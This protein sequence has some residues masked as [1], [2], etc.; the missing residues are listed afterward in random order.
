M[1]STTSFSQVITPEEELTILIRQAVNNNPDIE[2]WK[3][4][5]KASGERIP[6]AGSWN[7][8]I[9]TLG[10]NNL[11][12]NSFDFN[13]E[14]MTAF[15]ATFG[16]S[17]PLTGKY[18]QKKDIARFGYSIDST[19]MHD[20]ELTIAEDISR[21]YYELLFL[22]S[23]SATIDSTIG[24]KK[25]ILRLARRKYET[26]KGLQ[27]DILRLETEITK[28]YELKVLLEQQALSKQRQIEVLT[29]EEPVAESSITGE[30]PDSFTEIKSQSLESTLL[31]SNPS[32]ATA[33]EKAGKAEAE[34]NLAKQLRVPDL[35]LT[36]GYGYR[37]DA[38]N[39]ID[40]PDF[41]SLTAGIELPVFSSSKQSR[42]VL[43][44]K[45]MVQSANASLKKVELDLKLKLSTLIDQDKRLEE[46]IELYRQGIIPQTVA[47]LNSL[48][49]SY[50]VGKVEMEAL[51]STEASLQNYRLSLLKRIQERA[52]T[53]AAISALIGGEE[54][55]KNMEN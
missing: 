19:M 18:G 5:V 26:G 17:I 39:G 40:R 44:K 11:P 32:L 41:F 48:K 20:R 24:I 2:N 8:P 31:D 9:L 27:S 7:D 1:L 25:D 55:I 45:A 54:L 35:R 43:E 53:R 10:A 29:G 34:H 21:A 42:A 50:V 28:A 52:V 37:Q 13:Q 49:S 22:N 14:P 36:A 46:Q 16:Q 51:L 4:L 47:S 3:A 38:D 23:A 15:W 33:R 30:L 12:V 6:Q